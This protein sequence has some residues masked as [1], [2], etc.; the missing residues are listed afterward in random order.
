MND[1]LD[2]CILKSI[3]NS[4]KLGLEFCHDCS[5]K[6]FAPDLWRFS[7]A[8][9][10]YLRVYKTPPTKRT[11]IEQVKKNESLV[12]LFSETFDKI[13]AVEYN[14][15][16]YAF[17]LARLKDRYSEKL[18]VELQ[19]NL[20]GSEGRVD[21]KKG[22]SEIQ[23]TLNNVK[24]VSS[25]KS[26]KEGTIQDFAKEFD[27]LYKSKLENPEL[28]QGMMTGFNFLDSITNGLRPG[29]MA[30]VGGI[31]SAGKSVFLGNLGVQIWLGQNTLDTTANFRKAANVLII[32]L[33]MD[34]E[35]YY[36][37]LLSRLLMIPQ[38]SLQNA[39]L[40]DAEKV[41]VGKGLKWIKSYPYQMKVID[42]PKLTVASLETIIN[43]EISMGTKFDCVIIDYMNL[44]KGS[45]TSEQSDWLQQAIISEEIH[46]LART[47]EIVILSAVQINPKK[48]KSSEGTGFGIQN[49]RRATQIID[50]ADV[51]CIIQ[52][53]NNEK[54]YSDC[55]IEVVKNRRGQLSMGRLE[56]HLECCAFIESEIDV[57]SGGKYDGDISG[58][59]E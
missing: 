3:I 33:E 38:K 12:K 47:M 27:T 56:K 7:K 4:K 35:S 24:S 14:E 36:L 50:N 31:T 10:D 8:V 17:D 52:S 43:N 16:E 28:G 34:Y 53:R 9:M 42:I 30:L 29:E 54:N 46:T 41:K 32:S 19:K 22:I 15:K 59:V 13:M 58:L 23:N 55:M 2:L 21:V 40:T 6:L 5:E 57:S 45:N 20:S 1:N 11:L 25:V 48:D 49:I 51:F 18:I 26:F 44:V 37:R 39:T